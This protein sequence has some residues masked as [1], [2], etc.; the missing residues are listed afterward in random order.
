MLVLQFAAIG[1]LTSGAKAGQARGTWLSGSQYTNKCGDTTWDMGTSATSPLASDCD[2]LV[3]WMEGGTGGVMLSGLKTDGPN[4]VHREGSCSFMVTPESAGP[5]YVGRDDMADL[6]RDSVARWA[7]D[8][9]VGGGGAT[10]CG[11]MSITWSVG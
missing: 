10:R 7:R 3:K 4:L 6:V 8:G 5:F 11:D 1:L 9:R 2:A